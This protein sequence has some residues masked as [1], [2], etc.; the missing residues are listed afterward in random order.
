MKKSTGT[1]GAVAENSDLLRT[2]IPTS[3]DDPWGNQIN[4]ILEYAESMFAA[5]R[6]SEGAFFR[7]RN[8][9][10]NCYIER[11]IAEKLGKNAD[12]WNERFSARLTRYS[13][14][15]LETTL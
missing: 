11:R 2:H 1:T 3:P 8:I 14:R 5:G 10:L 13:D 15:L 4:A 12:V 9:L 7:F 6:L